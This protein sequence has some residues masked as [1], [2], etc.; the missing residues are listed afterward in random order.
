MAAWISATLSFVC[1]YF[2]ACIQRRKDVVLVTVAYTMA[3]VFSLVIFTLHSVMANFYKEPTSVEI[4]ANIV[5]LCGCALYK[6]ITIWTEDLDREETWLVRM[7]KISP[8]SL[9]L[10]DAELPSPRRKLL[11]SAERV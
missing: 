6:A 7:F 1:A 11:S 3:P 8:E 4:L 5:T 2:A 9:L 10:S